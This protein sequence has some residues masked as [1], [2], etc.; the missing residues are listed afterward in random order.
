MK[1]KFVRFMTSKQGRIGRVL[2][3][4]A[5]LSLSMFVVQGTPGKVMTAVALIPIAGGLFDFCLVG[6]ALG[7]PLS[8]SRARQLLAGK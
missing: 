8:G 4:I 1:E 7:Y 3:G 6:V 5:I 2:V